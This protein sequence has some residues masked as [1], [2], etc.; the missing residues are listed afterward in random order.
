MVSAR[1]TASNENI[2]TYGDGTRDFT[3]LATWEAATDIDLVAAAQSE[4]LECF[5]D[6]A[7]FDD[8]I[9]FSGAVTNS[10]FFRMIRPANGQGHDGTSN[11]GVT[12]ISSAVNSVFSLFED[13]AQVQDLVASISINSADVRIVF[14][15]GG[16]ST[17]VIGSIAFDSSNAGAGVIEGFRFSGG[18]TGSG[19]IL[20]LAEK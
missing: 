4:V 7:S 19:I 12:F 5:D 11:N 15:L 8:R 16:L 1:R 2:Q 17:R 20:C 10:S 14:F 18:S 3:A 6:A 13:N 9:T